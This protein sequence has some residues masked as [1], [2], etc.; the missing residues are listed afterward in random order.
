MS[1]RNV[2][3]I[4]DDEGNLLT[5]NAVS[6]VQY[7][8]N[9]TAVE[10]S[11]SDNLINRIKNEYSA[12][13]VIFHIDFDSYV[14]GYDPSV[15]ISREN[16]K[17]TRLIPKAAAQGRECRVN[18]VIL[19]VGGNGETL[20]RI[21]SPQSRIYFSPVIRTDVE[22]FNEE[23]QDLSSFTVYLENARSEIIGNCELVRE[24]ASTA[25]YE[26][27]LATKA[28]NVCN[29]AKQ[30][31]TQKAEEIDNIYQ[32]IKG[33]DLPE[34][35]LPAVTREDNGKFLRVIGG[36]WQAVKVSDGSEVAF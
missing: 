5:G 13:N 29:E 35:V 11:V 8:E 15:I 32:R 2:S 4:I 1:I 6:G 21:S 3:F 33:M 36:V 9:A 19:A 20:A 17:V 24:Y 23:V 26:N 25:T 12:Q 27:K 16:G 30:T 34:E 14:C 31:V 28:R 10:Y 18:L 22:K 7:E